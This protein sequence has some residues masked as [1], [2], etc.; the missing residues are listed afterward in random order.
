MT[1]PMGDQAVRLWMAYEEASPRDQELVDH[2]LG[3]D[4]PD[5][6]KDAAVS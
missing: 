1:P 2:I 3:L 5:D 6:K 4:I